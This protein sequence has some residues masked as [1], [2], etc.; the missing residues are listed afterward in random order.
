MSTGY[1]HNGRYVQTA[2]NARV[3]VPVSTARADQRWLTFDPANRK[4]LLIREGTMIDL[5]VITGGAYTGNK[6]VTR[7]QAY[8]MGTLVNGVTYLVYMK[9][10]GDSIILTL[11]ATE[12]DSLG[13]KVGSFSTLCADAGADL[14]SE[15]RVM[16]GA[17]A[18]G[19]RLL[20]KP[21]DSLLETDFYNFYN[22]E[23]KSVAYSNATYYDTV[24]CGHPLAGFVAGDILP[25][26][27]WCTTFRPSRLTDVGDAMCHDH[28]TDK[29]IDTY[30]MSGTNTATRSVYGAT[31][32]VS[33]TYE[34]ITRDLQTVGKVPLD[35]YEFY[36]AALGSNERTAITGSK[37]WTTVG[38]HVDTAGRRMISD[39]GCEEMNG[40][41]W[42]VLRDHLGCGGSNDWTSAPDPAARFGHYL[43]NPQILLAG[44]GWNGASHCGSACRAAHSG[45]VRSGS[46]ADGG[47]RGASYI[48]KGIR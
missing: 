3:L 37:D 27:V 13:Y 28:A 19:S 17:Y 15:H 20:L 2:G 26:S 32:T 35:D 5:A 40:Y 22:K 34:L 48:I 6:V 41:I 1:I 23:V 43:N 31:H 9:Y 10:T 46:G 42:H 29:A 4:G 24:L 16:H 30:I 11:S 45:T 8:D 33:R 7:D 47:S 39:I 14:T 25:E 18:A 36:H 44:G 21:Y 38:G 12:N